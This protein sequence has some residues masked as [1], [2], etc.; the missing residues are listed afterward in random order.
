M[1]STKSV[2]TEEDVQLESTD[3][4]IRS[5]GGKQITRRGTTASKPDANVAE[6]SSE[7]ETRF[8]RR[9]RSLAAMGREK[10]EVEREEE[11]EEGGAED[12]Q[13]QPSAQSKTPPRP[14]PRNRRPPRTVRKVVQS[15]ANKAAIEGLKKRME[16]EA[17]KFKTDAADIHQEDN[18]NADVAVSAPTETTASRLPLA[19]PQN[20]NKQA[21][22]TKQRPA[23]TTLQR[24]APGTIQRGAPN[25]I[26]RGAPHTIQRAAAAI[27]PTSTVKVQSTPNADTSVLALANFRRRPRQPSLLAMVQNPELAYGIDD[28]TDF[29]LGAASDEDEDDDGE[30]FAPH[31]EGTPI[32]LSRTLPRSTTPTAEH[33]RNVEPLVI[34]DDQDSL[35]DATPIATPQATRK[36]KSDAFDAVDN[37]Q[38]SEVQIP[39]SQS[40]MPRHSSDPLSSD[41]ADDQNDDDDADDTIPATAPQHSPNDSLYADPLSSSP[42]PVLPAEP[43]SHISPS[44]TTTRTTR[45]KKKLAAQS[46]KPLT[47]ATLRALLPKRRPLRSSSPAHN[48]R[49]VFDITSSSLGSDAS[50]HNDDDDADFATRGRRAAPAKRSVLSPVARRAALQG[51]KTAALPSQ[52]KT[53]SRAVTVSSDKENASTSSLSELESE[54]TPPD[55]S[56][57]TIKGGGVG[58]T[59][60]R[61]VGAEIDERRRFFEEVDEWE[62]EFESAPSLGGGLGSSPAW[63]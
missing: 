25:T 53:Y 5:S 42:P 46:T 38:E 27:A 60:G 59:K 63:R 16:E 51:R 8:R 9:S 4:L 54:G 57:E 48:E 58:L 21:P 37:L 31:D 30:G 7:D 50:S 1:A 19:P 44:P 56:V 43:T 45:D 15:E 24:K 47:T 49:S 26:Q 36:R 29:T 14:M 33:A 39:R 11:Q 6:A 32:Q 23:P 18:H 40:Y 52:K 61:K 12:N 3:P 2:R 10:R 22:T 17:N 13:D 55:T 28:S 41:P 34:S 20:V 35:Y 62:M